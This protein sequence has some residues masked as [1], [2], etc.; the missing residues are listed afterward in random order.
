MR[1][2]S[3]LNALIAIALLAE[4]IALTGHALFGWGP[5]PKLVVAT[6]RP[7][8]YAAAVPPSGSE[9]LAELADTA[10]RQPAQH[11]TA[12]TP[13]AYVMRTSWHL[14]AHVSRGSPIHPTQTQTWVR[15]DGAGRL[16]SATR[17]ARGW[18]IRDTTIPAGPPRPVL[19]ADPAVLE[20]TLDADGSPPAPPARVF[21]AFAELTSAEP[22]PPS[23]Q[24]AALRL[25]ALIP[26]VS[27]SGT[28]IDRD[29]RPGVAVSLS[30]D[31]TGALIRY[32]LIFDPA[33]GRLLEADQTVLGEGDRLP[34]QEGAVIG[35]TTFISSGYTANTMTRP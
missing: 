25:L 34:V 29:G 7:L 16:I 23:V 2:R 24:A 3:V 14:P 22:V 33:T 13:Y 30:S 12:R 27:N 10:A 6:P 28:V 8:V 17:S 31:Y 18:V 20:R 4:F 11:P 5:S 35:Y 26:G 19:S 9:M 21:Q 32:T 15:A 1:S